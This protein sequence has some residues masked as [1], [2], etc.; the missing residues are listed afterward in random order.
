MYQ[1]ILEKKK[2][3]GTFMSL[4][5]FLTGLV[6]FLDHTRLRNISLYV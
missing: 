5:A 6:Y 1:S 4:A 3:E 2:R